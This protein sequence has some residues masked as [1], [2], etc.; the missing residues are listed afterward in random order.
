MVKPA[1]SL[2][3]F[4]R[5]SAFS[6]RLKQP[7]AAFSQGQVI[8]SGKFARRGF[9]KRLVLPTGST[10][11]HEINC[12]IA[13]EWVAPY[14]NNVTSR[15]PFAHI[16]QDVQDG[17]PVLQMDCPV[18]MNQSAR[19]KVFVDIHIP[20]AGAKHNFFGSK[21]RICGKTGNLPW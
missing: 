19:I 14:T 5:P 10:S 11:I 8:Y 18:R 21:K 7:L 4:G 3:P 16:E 20:F 6:R 17:P 15:R 2:P 9:T 12:A 1:S 13:K